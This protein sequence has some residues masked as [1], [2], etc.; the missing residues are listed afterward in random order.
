MVEFVIRS[1]V[2]YVP[3]Y[4]KSGP[5][6]L[7]LLIWVT[8]GWQPNMHCCVT[9][10]WEVSYGNSTSTTMTPD[11]NGGEQTSPTSLVLLLLVSMAYRVLRVTLWYTTP[12]WFTGIISGCFNICMIVK[13]FCHDDVCHGRNL[14]AI[15]EKWK[16]WCEQ[17]FFVHKVIFIMWG[18]CWGYHKDSTKI[19]ITM[20][21][22]FQQNYFQIIKCNAWQRRFYCAMSTLLKSGNDLHLKQNHHEYIFASSNK[23]LN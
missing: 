17:C 6:D 1:F 2:A 4:L 7:P 5:V 12:Q 8:T 20:L 15:T 19:A 22:K 3:V 11:V 21:I 16:N 10:G 9:D 18:I 14:S 23:T 13:G